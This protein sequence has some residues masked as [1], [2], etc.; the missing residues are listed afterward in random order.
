MKEKFKKYHQYTLPDFALDD[1]YMDAIWHPTEDKTAYWKA[2]KDAFPHQTG[3]M[4]DAAMIIGSF[5]PSTNTVSDE[6]KNRI[7]QQVLDKSE[8]EKVISIQSKRKNYWWAAAAIIVAM[9]GGTWFVWNTGNSDN[10]MH[11]VNTVQN[12]IA[13]G[14]DR[15]ILTL[16]DGSQIVLDSAGNGLIAQEGAAKVIKLKSGEIA[17]DAATTASSEVHYNTIRTPRG[18]QYQVTLP[19]GTKV[20][21]NAESSLRYP[22]VFVKDERKVELTGEGYFEVARNEK[23][24]FYVSTDKM[25]IK[26]LGTHFNVN[27]YHDETY[28]K[29]TLLEGKVEVTTLRKKV[30]LNTGE[31][32]KLQ[33]LDMELKISKNVDLDEV[34]AWKEGLFYFSDASIET[35]MKQLSKWYDVDVIYQGQMP[36]RVF[37][38][39][40]QR[41]LTLSQALDLLGKNRINYEIKE[42][43]LIIKT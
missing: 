25:E 33:V 21:L 26:V 18:G 23:K 40:M 19:D 3:N 29:T 38:G 8:G 28:Y 7:W 27:T 10:P 17:Y 9:L 12:D 16:A 1:E 5:Q 20:W 15:A 13:P 30:T 42:K 14:G 4:E 43:N 37:R 24:P 34:M 32:A 35:V 39:G 36:D 6:I 11:Q 2:V 22:T 31:Q 41:S